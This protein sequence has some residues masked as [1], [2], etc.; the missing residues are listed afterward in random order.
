MS[1]VTIDLNID[2][3]TTIN[4]SFLLNVLTNQTLPYNAT[5]NPYTPLDL[6]GCTFS[7][8]VRIDYDQ[9]D[10]LDASTANGKIVVDTPSSGI[11]RLVLA[12]A[13]TTAINFLGDTANYVYDIELT[14]ASGNVSRPVKGAFNISREV[15]R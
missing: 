9:R 3:G 13:D 8:M 1:A 6:T 2:Q 14:D 12:P 4:Q 5:T 15:T 11:F 7:M 10:V